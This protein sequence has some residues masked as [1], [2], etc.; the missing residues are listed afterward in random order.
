MSATG[1][2]KLLE[3]LEKMPSG[4]S[5][6]VM[7]KTEW[8]H[9]ITDELENGALRIFSEYEYFNVNTITVPGAVEIPFAIQAIDGSHMQA[10]V[11]IAFACVI[12]GDT[13]HFDY[14]CQS[15]TQG[16]TTLNTE[17]DSPVIYGVLTVE[18]ETQALERIGGKHGHKGEEAA[19]T[20]LKMLALKEL[21][22][23]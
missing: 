5:R 3:G 23:G 17:L 6:I 20:A 9:A 21:L 4:E 1:N 15:I 12:R 10:D 8:N 18:N 13:P 19:I 2:K 11:Y 14:V 16:I 22:V 7:V